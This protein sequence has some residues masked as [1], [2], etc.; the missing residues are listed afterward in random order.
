MIE[1]KVTLYNITNV[2]LVLPFIMVLTN[3]FFVD[4]ELMHGIISGK[5]FHF[6]FSIGF[7][8]LML[9]FFILLKNKST[10]F[11][12]IDFIILLFYI[13]GISV[14]FYSSGYVNTKIVILTLLVALYVYFRFILT[15]CKKNRHIFLVTLLIIGVIES[16]IGLLQLYGL[17]SSY[18][19]SFKVTG[20]FFN[21]GPYAG[22]LAMIFPIAFYY[23]LKD[24]T[25]IKKKINIKF[26]LYYIRFALSIIVLLGILLIIPATM[27]R[28]SWI[29][30]TGGCLIVFILKWMPQQ[31]IKR[32]IL[33]NRK[34]VII[35]LSISIFVLGIFFWN[36]YHLKK[37]SADGRFLMW[38]ISAETIKQ[39]PWGVGLGNFSGSYGLSQA[40]YFEKEISS[41][42]EELVA[43]VPQYAFNEYLQICIELGVISFLLFLIIL[44]C[45][46]YKGIRNKRYPEIGALVSLLL[47]AF[48]SYPF[49]LLPFLIVFVFLLASC[50]SPKNNRIKKGSNR[51]LKIY[52]N[53]IIICLS[54]I[55]GL[56]LY[57]RYPTYDAYKKWK[58]S[59]MIYDMK[60]YSNVLE[61]YEELYPYLKDQSDFLFEYGHSL[62]QTGKFEKSN[63]IM[64]QAIKLNC[65]HMFYNIFGK[66]YQNL[67]KYELAEQYLKK[68][69]YLAPNRIYPYYLLAKLYLEWNRYD[70]A[71]EMAEIVMSKSPKVHSVAIDEMREEMKNILK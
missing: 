22:Y 23:M 67:G 7:I 30:V 10:I 42:Q 15:S 12:R 2:L 54:V 29:A 69:S 31:D 34:K 25:L 27:S 50:I 60:M 1:R 36:L 17:S 47:F 18:H 5:Y 53:I 19:N 64:L 70:K 58:Y 13:C 40:N 14:S 9:L 20:T 62:S 52:N 45:A 61:E 65:D 16:I 55:V 71:K 24:Y 6:Y 35:F 43:G 41:N 59:K 4:N 26:L 49:N 63:T 51:Y 44:S 46:I 56:C 48:M 38:K 11:T 66:D 32:C 3:A 68:S 28:A 33:K 8:A 37:D 21:P 57:N 39:N